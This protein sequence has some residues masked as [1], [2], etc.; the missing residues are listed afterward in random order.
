MTAIVGVVHAGRVCIST[1]RADAKVFTNGPAVFGFTSS[2]RMGQLLRHSLKFPERGDADLERWLS[3][4]FVDAVR[5]CL[6]DG[7]YARKDDEVES[8][9]EFLVG[10]FG[11]LFCMHSDYQIAEQTEPWYAI[12]QGCEVALGSMWSTGHVVGLRDQPEARVRLALQAAANYCTGVRGPFV[13]VST[14]PIP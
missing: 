4:S 13:I 11:R 14:E 8:A 12:G 2:F 5:Q 1:A 6:K 9:G 3:T 7:G 10:M